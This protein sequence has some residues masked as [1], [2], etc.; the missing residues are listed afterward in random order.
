MGTMMAGAAEVQITPPVGTEL[1]GYFHPRVSDG[2][3]SELMAKSVVVGEGDE[4]VAVCACDLITMTEEISSEAREIIQEATGIPGGRVMICATHTHT[5]PELRQNR[6]IARNE[7]WIKTLPGLIAESVIA[8]ADNQQE[9]IV[10]VGSDHEEGLA[11]NR[12]FRYKDGREEFGVK[13]ADEV[14]GPAGPTDPELGVVT[15]RA[16]HNEDPFAMICNYSLHIDVT[17]GNKISA[18][19]PAVM[20]DLLR[21]VYGEDLVMLYVQGACGNINHVPYMLDRPWPRSGHDKSVQI[22]RALGGKA[23]GIAE[24]ALPSMRGGVDASREILQVAAY[25]ID[26][27]VEKR[28]E[29]AREKDKPHPAEIRMMERME[30]YDEDKVTPRETQAIRIGDAV[31]CSA[32]GE[33]FVEWGLEIKKWSPFEYTFIAEL[34]NDSVGYIPTWEAFRR[35]G[36]EA[37][38]ICSVVSHPALGQMIADAQFR[39]CQAFEDRSEGAVD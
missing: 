17:S 37:T 9:A 36:Y 24:K 26:D 32:P 38:P 16:D 34:A 28:L 39:A 29:Q 33:Y 1:A 23:L 4:R 18:D 2:V 13:D 10:G 5:G 12:R 22:G 20:T 21:D 35:G 27:V 11:F 6:P 19:F 14:V 31:F 25:P 7:E 30:D 8:A 15:F 3:I